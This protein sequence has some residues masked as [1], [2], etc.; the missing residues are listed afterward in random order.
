M[1]I[2]HCLRV[3]FLS[4]KIIEQSGSGPLNRPL[5]QAVQNTIAVR[6]GASTS[7]TPRFSVAD[8]GHQGNDTH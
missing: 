8:D 2:I 5:P 7:G 4:F 6:A 1:F 3:I